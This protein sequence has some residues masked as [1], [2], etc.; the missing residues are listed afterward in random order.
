MFL[1]SKYMQ[2]IDGTRVN[3]LS[4]LKWDIEKILRE[5]RGITYKNEREF[6][7]PSISDLHNPFL[8]PDMEKA[9]ERILN[10]R[11]KSERIVIFWDYDVDGVSSTALLVRFLTEIGCI[12]SYRLP[13]RS[14]DGYGL[15]SYV[16]DELKEKDVA[17]VITVDCGTRDIEPIRHAKSLW[18]D[19]IVTDHHA[20]PDII[21]EEVIALLNPKRKDSEYPFQNLAWSGVAFKLIHWILITIYKLHWWYTTNRESEGDKL[22]ESDDKQYNWWAKANEFL[23]P[24]EPFVSFQLW[25]EKDSINIFGNK[26]IV[27]ETLMRYIDFASLWTVADCMPLTWENRVI[28]TLGLRQMKNSDSAWLRKFLESKDEAEWNADI[29]GFQI[30][31]RINASGRMDT[32]LTALRWLL[33]SE[34]RCD[35]FLEEIECLNTKRQEIVKDFSEKALESADLKK[36]ILF[37]RDNEIGH[38]LIGL[39]AGKLTEAY[40]RPAITLC[41]QHGTTQKTKNLVASCRSPE[42]C[43]LVELLDECKEFFVRYGGHRQAAGFTI[44]ESRY[45]EFQEVIEKKFLEKYGEH[46]ELPPKTISIECEITTHDL[47]LWTLEMLGKFKPFGI[48]N[49]KPIFLVRDLT[50]LDVRPLGQSGQHMSF[51]CAEIPR[52]RFLA[53]RVEWSL[54]KELQKWNI[55]SPIIELGQN[56]WNGKISLQCTLI[57]ILSNA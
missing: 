9:I 1:K 49:R 56:E 14:K 38:G 37:Y 41:E 25:K 27:N 3:I 50:I 29:I 19:V 8:M 15:K 26:S 51:T 35:E 54:Q 43:N 33:A 30:W 44:E 34:E 40:N 46:T 32:P 10:A 2:T 23:S 12:V 5:N 18:I 7:S 20:V 24:S 11:E 39:V 48:A 17:L 42:W 45:R 55:I 6:F 31:P 16:F 28:A 52:I 36:W 21:P 4:H 53:W 13:H 47:S 57:S 22:F